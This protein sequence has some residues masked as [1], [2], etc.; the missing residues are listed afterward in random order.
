[1]YEQ[2]R[3]IHFYSYLNKSFVLKKMSFYL[4]LSWKKNTLLLWEFK[5]N[6]F[7]KICYFESSKR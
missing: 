7:E 2:H 6:D 1:M 3:N 4:L 5:V